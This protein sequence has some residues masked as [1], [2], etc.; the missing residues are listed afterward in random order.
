MTINLDLNNVQAA[1]DALNKYADDLDRKAKEITYRVASVGAEEVVRVDG[2]SVVSWVE[3][4]KD[5]HSMIAQSPAIVFLEFGTG[6]RTES[7]APYADKVSV[8]VWPGSW[9]DEHEFK[10]WQHWIES[11]KDP[12]LYPYNR[13]PKRGMYGAAQRMKREIKDIAKAVFSE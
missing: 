6:V 1:I 11:G 13:Y 4:T 8:N 7:D 10:T 3:P 12:E 9:S 2:E 5:G